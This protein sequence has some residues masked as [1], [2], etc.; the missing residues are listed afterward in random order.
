MWHDDSLVPP[1][2]S[3]CLIS[4]V[5]SFFFAVTI[6]RWSPSAVNLTSTDIL[7]QEGC[8]CV[9]ICYICQVN[10]EMYQTLKTSLCDALGACATWD[11][12]LFSYLLK[13]LSVQLQQQNKSVQTIICMF[14][15]AFYKSS[16]AC[17]LSSGVEMKYFLKCLL[18]F[19][20][21]FL[22]ANKYSNKMEQLQ[23]CSSYILRAFTWGTFIF[24]VPHK[25]ECQL[26]LCTSSSFI[27]SIFS[28]TNGLHVK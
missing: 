6:T 8:G 19:F 14:A 4:T 2:Q 13:K 20:C 22:Y 25:W 18:L 1:A 3:T 9:I 27:I 15:D 21:W 16:N 23:R 28:K 12:F 5:S 11:Y 7:C 17:F 26:S 10:W 24:N